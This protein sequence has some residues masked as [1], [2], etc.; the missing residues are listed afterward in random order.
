VLLCPGFLLA[1]HLRCPRSVSSMAL[2]WR[3]DGYILPPR[4]YPLTGFAALARLYMLWLFPGAALRLYIHWLLAGAA[5]H[6]QKYPYDCEPPGPR[7]NPNPAQLLITI[8]SITL[9]SL[10]LC[11]LSGYV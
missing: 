10:N 9:F 3:C 5:H 6:R 7:C 1:L 11:S 2:Y 8:Q 4:R